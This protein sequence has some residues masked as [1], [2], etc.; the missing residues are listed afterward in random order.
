M[1]K[2]MWYKMLAAIFLFMYMLGMKFSD[3]SM[4][5]WQFWVLVIA[6]V[7]QTVLVNWRFKDE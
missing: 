5:T 6:G 2:N 4:A 1:S 3:F 7:G